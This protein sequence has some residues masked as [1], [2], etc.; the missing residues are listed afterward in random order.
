MIRSVVLVGLFAVSGCSSSLDIDVDE[1]KPKPE[2]SDTPGEDSGETGETDETGDSDEPTEPE[3]DPA[4]DYE[5]PGPFSAGQSWSEVTGRSGSTLYVSSWFPSS[6]E[7]VETTWYGWS[8]WYHRGESFQD[9]QPA[10]EEPLN[11]MVHSHGNTSVSWEMFYLHEFLAT[12]GWLIIAP[13]HEG[14]TLYDYSASFDQVYL[15]R[16]QDI[17]DSYDWLVEQSE[18][19]LSPFYG[20]VDPDAGYVVSG[21]SFGGYTAYATGGALVNNEAGD[22]TVD[23]SDSRV[24]GV[25]TYAPWN[26]YGLLTTG[27][28][29]VDVPTLTVGGERDDTVG[30]QY[31]GMH[32]QIEAIPRLMGSLPNVG[33]FSFTPLYCWEDGDGCGD[34][35]YDQT[36]FTEILKTTVLSWVEFL[37]GRPGAFEQIPKSSDELQWELVTE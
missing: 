30:V 17:Q 1:G 14:N 29:Q 23:A 25:I 31:K 7:G 11:I 24:T 34:D 6:E 2:D 10:C 33:H 4:G 5:S 20:C 8:G 3:L 12:H 27:M 35:Y 32:R 15:R 19:P 16:P 18:D 9:L 26:G 22:P 37:K 28:D 13:D 21:Y 36:E